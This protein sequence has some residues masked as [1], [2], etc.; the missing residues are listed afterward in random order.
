[1]TQ[2]QT[3]KSGNSDRNSLERQGTER[4]IQVAAFERGSKI[5]FKTDEMSIIIEE[6]TPF[7]NSNAKKKTQVEYILEH[8]NL[9][10]SSG[11]KA[12]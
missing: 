1:M 8:S 10:L 5:S 9:K 6:D 2:R 3:L 4:D 12:F 7:K 11:M